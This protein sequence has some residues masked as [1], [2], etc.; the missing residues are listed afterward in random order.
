MQ[1]HQSYTRFLVASVAQLTSVWLALAPGLVM[2]MEEDG[3]VALEVA[4]NGGECG[5]VASSSEHPENALVLTASL[6]AGHCEGCHD[7]PLFV[8]RDAA[9]QHQHATNVTAPEASTVQSGVL[10]AGPL[11]HRQP[12]SAFAQRP[13]R[14]SSQRSTILRI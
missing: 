4:V 11:T 3:Q 13:A 6:A 10:L 9:A 2:C 8:A 5:D 7:V 14:I 1:R 12:V